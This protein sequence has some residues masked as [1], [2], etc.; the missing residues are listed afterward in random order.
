M[1]RGVG[2]EGA[3]ALLQ[4]VLVKGPHLPLGE[5]RVNSKAGKDKPIEMHCPTTISWVNLGCR[6][7]RLSLQKVLGYSG[8]MEE[9]LSVHLAYKKWNSQMGDSV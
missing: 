6:H 5:V 3:D 4:D 8:G 7:D 9:R 2:G 1:C